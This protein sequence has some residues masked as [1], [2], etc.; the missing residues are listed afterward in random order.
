MVPL[1][2]YPLEEESVNDKNCP[3]NI[4]MVT[5]YNAVT[6]ESIEQMFQKML[7]DKNSKSYGINSNK[8]PLVAQGHGANG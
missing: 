6:M 4:Y 7:Q 1:Y 5:S 2:K 8:S 3:H